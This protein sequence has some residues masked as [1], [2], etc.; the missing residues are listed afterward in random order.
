L[1]ASTGGGGKAQEYFDV[2]G[3]YSRRGVLAIL[4][5]TVEAAITT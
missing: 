1:N 4:S 5:L 2:R 3:A